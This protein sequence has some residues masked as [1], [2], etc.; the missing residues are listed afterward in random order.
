MAKYFRYVNSDDAINILEHAITFDKGFYFKEDGIVLGV[1]LLATTTTPYMAFAR[2]ARKRLGLWNASFL[3]LGFG[4][5]RPKLKD[6]LKLE[7]IAVSPEARGKGVGTQML[8]H[9]NDLAVEEG[10]KRITLEVIDSNEKAMVLYQKRGFVNKKYTNT[11]FFTKNLG[12]RGY[13]K[14]QIDLVV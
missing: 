6:G 13:Y 8:N 2:H 4:A 10:F 9:L 12:F 5:M 3:R 7:M 11:A 1:A 14:M